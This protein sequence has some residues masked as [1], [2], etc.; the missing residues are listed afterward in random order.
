MVGP[1]GI[2]IEQVS[3]NVTFAVRRRRSR[4]LLWVILLGI[5]AAAFW[6]MVDLGADRVDVDKSTDP[7][8]GM[9]GTIL[10]ALVGV[11]APSPL[12]KK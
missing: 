5:L 8:F 3:S 6:C 2:L 7:Y 9:A 4:V 10:G 11:I 12:A 1:G